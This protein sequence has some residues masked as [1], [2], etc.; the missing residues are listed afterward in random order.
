MRGLI[1]RNYCRSSQRGGRLC[2]SRQPYKDGLRTHRIKRGLAIAGAALPLALAA[3]ERAL[4]A[5]AGRAPQMHIAEGFLPPLWAALWFAACVPVWIIGFRSLR[6]I[7]AQRA[8]NRLLLALAAAYAFVLSSLKMPLVTGSSSHPTGTG[9]GA[10]LFGPWA[11]SIIGAIV[12]LFQALLLAHGG[13]TTLG[14][15]TFSMAITGPVI[16]YAVFRLARRVGLPMAIAVFLCAMLAD[17]ST[18]VMTSLQLAL[19]FPSTPGGVIASFM[20][21][22]ALFA[23]TQ[24]PIAISEGMLTVII[25]R[26]LKAQNPHDISFTLFGGTE[27]A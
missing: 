4:A 25:V 5:S 14:A 9:L 27:A 2:F 24:V 8:E 26:A 23:I 6:H 10:M 3:A 11:M 16:G 21:F 15:N 22:C 12:L 7:V 18:Y 19:A 1:S 13:L 17:L 20:R